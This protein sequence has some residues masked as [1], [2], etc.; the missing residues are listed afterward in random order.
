M[1]YL[2]LFWALPLGLFWGWYWIS[3]HDLNLGFAFLSRQANDLVFGIYGN[4]LGIDPATI[5]GLVGRATV[6]DSFLLFGILAFRRRK[7]ILAWL[8]ER[9]ERH[10]T[11]GSEKPTAS[12]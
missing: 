3:Y 5:P 7:A 10:Q 11:A 1:R 6:F 2:L 8:R 12:A 4:V 9:G